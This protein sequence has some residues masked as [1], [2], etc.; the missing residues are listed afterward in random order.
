MFSPEAVP[1]TAR[2]AQKACFFSQKPFWDWSKF[3]THDQKFSILVLN[4][5]LGTEF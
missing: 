1:V 5:F 3:S 2:Q 4:V